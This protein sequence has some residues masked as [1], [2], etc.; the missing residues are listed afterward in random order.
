[1]AMPFD[2]PAVVRVQLPGTRIRESHCSPRPLPVHSDDD[3]NAGGGV[4]VTLQRE[5]HFTIG[6]ETLGAASLS[7]FEETGK[8]R[9][10]IEF[11][12]LPKPNTRHCQL[13]PAR[14][15]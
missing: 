3:G 11:S 12:D 9:S 1:M 5:S 10:S 6:D 13:A 14:H 4:Q 8:C 7:H 2:A 15:Q